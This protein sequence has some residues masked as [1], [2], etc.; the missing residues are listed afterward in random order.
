MSDSVSLSLLHTHTHTQ[1]LRLL[2]AC[3]KYYRMGNAILIWTDEKK[4]R[5]KKVSLLL[6]IYHHQ[7]K[8]AK[9]PKN[10]VNRNNMQIYYCLTSS[11]H[12]SHYMM[13]VKNKPKQDER[14][15]R[16]HM[17]GESDYWLHIQSQWSMVH[18]LMAA[19]PS[20]SEAQD[21]LQDLIPRNIWAWMWEALSGSFLTISFLS[22]L[23]W[24]IK[25]SL[26]AQLVMNLPMMQ[27]TRV[28]C[29]AQEDPLEEEM[30]THSSILAGKSH[31]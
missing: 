7:I 24:S 20:E 11:Q 4:M 15:Q 18:D 26:V 22:F 13:C 10:P 23:T 14:L 27:E 25:A 9:N 3:H 19:S 29:L 5:K 8:Q 21:E 2:P 28:Q 31:G 6:F 30:A 16:K 12:F 17:S 1:H